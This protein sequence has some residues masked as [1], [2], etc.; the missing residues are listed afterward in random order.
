MNSSNKCKTAVS[1]GKLF[2]EGGDEKRLGTNL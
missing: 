2:L 1:Y